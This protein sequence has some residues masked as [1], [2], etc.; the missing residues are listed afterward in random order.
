MLSQRLALLPVVVTL[1]LAATATSA[2]VTPASLPGD[3]VWYLHADLEELRGA[4]SGKR[5]YEWLEQEAF[6]DIREDLGIDLG[7]EANWVTAFADA[8]LGT[9]IVVDGAISETT[10]D[11]LLALASM[12]AKLDTLNHAGKTYYHADR[13][14]ARSHNK[15]SFD[16]LQKSAYFS[17]AVKD[18]LIV[19]SD[20]DQMTA[21]L[22]SDG[23]IAGNQ[24]HPGALLVL[25]A[26]QSFVQAGVRTAAF[27]DEDDQGWDSNILRNTELV[28]LL[29]SDSNGHIAIEA[30]LVSHEPAMAQ[31]LGGIINGLISLQALDQ[32]L[33]PQIL[34]L[35]RNTKIDVKDKILSINAV[36]DPEIIV[37]LLND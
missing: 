14:N 25:T 26:D 19:A 7:K 6:T 10:R 11:K 4:S 29:V 31:S 20:P 16:D 21:L 35:I 3:T 17:F 34:S 1:G 33:D 9:V 27:A 2:Q 32:D 24:S 18:K 37:D 28:A 13:K 12:D 30:Q 36:L 22:D 23:R 8:S 15:Q 5:I